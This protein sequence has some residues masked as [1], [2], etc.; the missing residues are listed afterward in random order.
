MASSQSVS[1]GQRSW[2]SSRQQVASSSSS[3]ASLRWLMLGVVLVLLVGFFW[4]VWWAFQEPPHTHLITLETGETDL[5]LPSILFE[6]A[7]LEPFTAIHNRNKLLE[8]DV[9]SSKA[10]LESIENFTSILEKNIG[11]QD[12]LI[13]YVSAHGVSLVDADAR[14]S[15]AFFLATSFDVSKP[16]EKSGRYPVDDLI[17]AIDK[18]PA[19]TKLLVLDCSRLGVLPRAGLLL[20]EFSWLDK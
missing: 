6:Q 15:N 10:S 3:K 7:T 19:A 2:R 1:S 5:L 11:R 20:N 18:V 12:R 9:E 16:A 13:V 8:Y 17:D 14:V 4:I